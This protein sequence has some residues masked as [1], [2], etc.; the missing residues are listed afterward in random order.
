MHIL[1]YFEQS[2]QK[3]YSN[4]DKMQLVEEIIYD[5]EKEKDRTLGNAH[6]EK[7]PPR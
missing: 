2:D 4:L 1:E 5:A 7:I 6:F 3:Q